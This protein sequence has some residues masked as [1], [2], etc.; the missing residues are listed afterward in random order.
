[1]LD[2]V[3][4]KWINKLINFVVNSPYKCSF[5]RQRNECTLFVLRTNEA[6]HFVELRS[7]YGYAFTSLTSSITSHVHKSV[8]TQ[9]SDEAQA[10][11]ES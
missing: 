9:Q 11:T 3:M 7:H 4:V 5:F 8:S 2:I 10:F 1:M 6:S